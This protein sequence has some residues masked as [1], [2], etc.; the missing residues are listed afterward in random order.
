[1]KN[2]INITVKHLFK[3]LLESPL[4][5]GWIIIGTI[6]EIML[7]GYKGLLINIINLILLTFF[8]IVIKIMTDSSP[9]KLIPKIKHPRLELFSG[10]LFYIFLFIETS[11][12]WGQANIPYLSSGITNLFS[13]IESISLKFGNIGVPIWVLTLL[14]NAALVIVIEL[15]PIVILFLCWGYGFKKMGFIFSNL[16]LILVLVGVTI[17]LGLHSRILFQQPFYKTIITFFISIFVNGLPEELILRGY[18]LPRFEAVFKNSI[19]A[20]V[21]VAIL[22]NIFHVPTYLAKGVSMYQILM[23][24]FSIV[25]PSGLIWGYLYLKTRSIVPGIIWHTSNAILGIIFLS[26]LWGTYIL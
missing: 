9:V 2:T 3:R 6:I 7:N 11:I 19:N 17:I 16:R 10:I 5:L 8:T 15:I 20:L 21:I 22:F 1:M 12:F 25:Y 13:S 18:L 14:S 23:T 4:L 24:S 26:S